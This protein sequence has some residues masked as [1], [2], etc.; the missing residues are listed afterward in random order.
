MADIAA[1]DV[2]HNMHN[3]KKGKD[4]AHLEHDKGDSGDS[5]LNDVEKTAS[6]G[7]GYDLD[8][9]PMDNGEYKVT[10]KTWAVVMVGGYDLA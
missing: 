3:A 10:A 7:A 9:I 8:G 1:A 2:L 4:H 6:H 5:S